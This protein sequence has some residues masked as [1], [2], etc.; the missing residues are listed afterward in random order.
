[1]QA[2]AALIPTLK[3]A[4]SVA[5]F[6]TETKFSSKPRRE[7]RD[8]HVT[9][10][11]ENTNF[12]SASLIQESRKFKTRTSIFDSCPKLRNVNQILTLFD[13]VAKF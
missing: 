2:A 8:F 4:F 10:C 3:L 7:N 9:K 11:S 5:L 12:L 13:F 6:R 1:M